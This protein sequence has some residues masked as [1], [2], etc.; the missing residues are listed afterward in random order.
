MQMFFCYHSHEKPYLS[1]APYCLSDTLSF[2]KFVHFESFIPFLIFP[3]WY[4]FLS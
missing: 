3:V 1:I 4:I 2:S